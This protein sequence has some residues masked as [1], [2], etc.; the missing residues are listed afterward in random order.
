M[1]KLI[2]D[3][4]NAMVIPVDP[5]KVTKE[6]QTDTNLDIFTRLIPIHPRHPVNYHHC[7]IEIHI[8]RKLRKSLQNRA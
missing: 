3:M 5:V 8:F 2:E 6:G 7:H 1:D 4:T